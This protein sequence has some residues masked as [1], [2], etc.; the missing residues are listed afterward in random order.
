[1]VVVI[2]AWQDVLKVIVTL[3]CALDTLENSIISIKKNK[4]HLVFVKEGMA[5]FLMAGV[6]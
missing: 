6:F 3:S 4:Q 1:M 2:S 5:F